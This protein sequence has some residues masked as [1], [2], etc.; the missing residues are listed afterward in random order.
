MAQSEP[1]L[2][3]E[4]KE[5]LRFETLLSEIS[6]RFINPSPV[7]L[8]DAIKDAQLRICELLDIDRFV[9]WQIQDGAPGK[10][11]LSHIHQRREALFPEGPIDARDYFP[12]ILGRVL[13][14][15]VVAIRN[16]ADFPPEAGCDR[17]TFQSWGITSSVVVPMSIDGN[18][19][20]ALSFARLR[21]ECDWPEKIVK[22]FQL[23]A[24]IFANV[25]A[26]KTAEDILRN[27]LRFESLLTE[28]STRF[29]NLPAEQVDC[30]IEAVQQCICE[31]LG[32]ESSGVWQLSNE[33]TNALILTHLYRPL[34]GPSVPDR[35][36][37]SEFF[38]WCLRKL[39]N[40]NVVVN[41]STET[42]PEEAAI[43]KETFRKYGIKS[44]LTFPLSVGGAPLFGAM[45]VNTTLKERDWPEVVVKQ[46]QLVAQMFANALARKVADL[47]L[48][49]RE[50]RLSLASDAAGLG[51]W[52]MNIDTE[53]VWATPK[54][55]E[56]FHFLPDET[57]T[58][59]G[60]LRMIHP[61]DRE[62]VDRTMFRVLQSGET[63]VSEY[64]IVLPDGT[65]R[66]IGASGRLYRR[67]EEEPYCLMGVSLDITPF[68]Q[69]ESRLHEGLKEITALKCRLENENLYLRQELQ[70]EHGFEKIVGKSK[71]FQSVIVSAGQ[72]APTDATVLLLGETGS[73]KGMVANAIYQMSS[74]KNRPFITVNCSALPENLIESELF[75]REKG[76]FTGAHARQAGRFEIAN[77]G[78]IFLDEIGEMPLGLQSKLLRV[79]QEGEFERVGSSKTV[80]VDVRVIAATSRDLNE[81]IRDRRFRKDLFYRLNVFPISLPPLRQRAE[82]IPLLAEYFTEKYARRMGKQI[83]SIPSATIKAF[84]TYDW[85]GNVRELEH[86]IERGV[87]ITTGT[88]FRM[89]GEL[90]SAIP[91]DSGKEFLMDLAAAERE[92]ILRVLHETGWRIEGA[93]GAAEILKLHPSTLRFRIKKLGIRRPE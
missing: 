39:Q 43:D 55:R 47:E 2:R 4:L 17:E 11:L 82:D 7:T 61:E 86:V 23:V 14:G 92:H 79:L 67:S 45:G 24:Q 18:V 3:Q 74:R 69:M 34:G 16:C 77:G 42:L 89:A 70:M 87:I 64:R 66:W 51:L 84:M 32:L 53:N 73:G 31:Y 10:M 37:A 56:L 19:I 8:D 15:E 49:E 78:T 88:S 21:E 13:K 20:G 22:R 63:L 28:I 60:F 62:A 71:A 58:L 59:E 9:L 46:L 54:T 35:M 26:R 91:V 40:G 48:R 80:K 93:S 1:D 36:N 12:W 25:V 72:V 85:P 57:L 52:I 81:E 44:S 27:Q 5:R 50:A 38:P 68:K 6:F 65:I 83:R 75:G 29:I 30:E 33:A 76:A 41:T 90:C